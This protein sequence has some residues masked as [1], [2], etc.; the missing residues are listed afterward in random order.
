MQFWTTQKQKFV[1]PKKKY[2]GIPKKKYEGTQASSC[3]PEKKYQGNQEDASN[4]YKEL[5]ITQHHD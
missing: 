5:N 2:E 4:F 1:F 3:G